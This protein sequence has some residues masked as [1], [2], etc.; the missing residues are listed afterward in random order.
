M[1]NKYILIIF[2]GLAI[3]VVAAMIVFL[4]PT[5]EKGNNTP[6]KQAEM[7]KITT[8]WC[9]LA[10][11]PKETKNFT[12]YTEGSPMT[13]TFK[14]SFSSSNDVL[15]RWIKESPG[16][17]DAKIEKISKNKK[18]YIILP[19]GGAAYAEVVI[20]HETKKVTSETYWS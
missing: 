20:D 18:K 10:P 19:G 2:T 7:I 12:I 16:L 8:E 4:I 14:G 15:E 9:R 5:N 6:A 11:F 13:R 3:F 1:N 17:M